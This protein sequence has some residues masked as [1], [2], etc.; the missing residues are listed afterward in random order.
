MKKREKEFLLQKCYFD[1]KKFYDY[2][3]NT[4]VCET[5]KE[6]IEI[7]NNQINKVMK[8]YEED[9]NYPKKDKLVIQYESADNNFFINSKAIEEYL[10]KYFTR[11][12]SKYTEFEIEVI[13][14]V[15]IFKGYYL[16]D[17]GVN[18]LYHTSKDEVKANIKNY[19]IDY[20]FLGI[21]RINGLTLEI[22]KKN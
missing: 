17:T 18:K 13:K 22:E 3:M 8:L 1:D 15:D 5:F 2:Y 19:N 10:Y 21:L 4:L 12:F 16:F 9:N 20:G 11:H 14:L 6:F 7:A